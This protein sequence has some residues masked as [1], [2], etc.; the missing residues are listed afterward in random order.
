MLRRIEKGKEVQIKKE[1]LIIKCVHTNHNVLQMIW[2]P[3]GW[4][5]LI[6]C[7]YNNFIWFLEVKLD[8]NVGLKSEIW[9]L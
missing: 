1:I 6:Y 2:R 9:S 8:L 4:E 3:T 5:P 7:V